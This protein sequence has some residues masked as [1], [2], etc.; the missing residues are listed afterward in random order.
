MKAK[1]FDNF[2]ISGVIDYNFLIFREGISKVF[3]LRTKKMDG[4]N[5]DDQSEYGGFS[6]SVLTTGSVAQQYD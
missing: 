5:D 3:E 4:D 6:S 2:L 1:T